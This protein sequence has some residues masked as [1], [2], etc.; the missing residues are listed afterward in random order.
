[1]RE[2]SDDRGWGIA[3]SLE[4]PGDVWVHFSVLEGD[5]DYRNMRS[6]DAIS[7]TYEDAPDDLYG[8]RHQAKTARRL[9]S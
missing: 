9:T 4:V 3:T 2:W 8:C 6:G 5:D 1:M 7:F